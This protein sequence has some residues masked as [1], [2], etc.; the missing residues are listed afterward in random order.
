MKSAFI[1]ILKV[2]GIVVS[3]PR[4]RLMSKAILPISRT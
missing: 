1:D 3:A 4:A 2:R